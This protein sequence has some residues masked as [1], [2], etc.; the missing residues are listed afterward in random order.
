LH[1]VDEESL[2]EDEDGEWVHDE[3]EEED[4]RPMESTPLLPIFSASHLGISF[5]P[6]PNS[7]SKILPTR[8]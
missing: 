8:D 3:D 4:E 2:D 6:F 7:V 1:D 5:C